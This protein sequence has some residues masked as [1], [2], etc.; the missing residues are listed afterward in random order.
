MS[1]PT[2]P[3]ILYENLP[4]YTVSQWYENISSRIHSESKYVLEFYSSFWLIPF[5]F[6][7][8]M[9]LFNVM[10]GALPFN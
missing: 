5:L 1:E 7:L 8:L 6:L 3:P 9:H 2:P 4:A 10:T